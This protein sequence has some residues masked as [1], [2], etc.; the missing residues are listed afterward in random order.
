MLK[1]PQKHDLSSDVHYEHRMIYPLL[2]I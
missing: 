1:L 2:V